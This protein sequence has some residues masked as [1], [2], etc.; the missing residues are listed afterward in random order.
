MLMVNIIIL[1]GGF[2]GIRA[3]LTL[4]NKINSGNLH[5]MII[6][7]N[8][9]HTFT[10]ALYE[11]A[12]AEELSKNAIIPYMSIFKNPLEFVRGNVE[13]IDAVGQKIF[14][15]E[16]REYAYNYLIFAPGSNSADF[17][18]PGIKEYAVPLITLEDAVRIKNALKNAKRVIVGGGGFTGTEFACELAT[19][20][21]H[22]NITLI[23]GLPVLLKELGDEVSHLAK[24]RLEK[25]NVHLI[26][27]KH[28]KK[29]TKD[30][31][32]IE[33][34]EVF[35]YDLFVWT[36]GVRPNNLLGKIEVET[37][38]AVKNLKNVFAAGDSVAPGVAP[39]AEEMGKLA[40]E[41]ILRSIN[42]EPL[43]PFKYHHKGYVVPLGSRF[44]TYVIGK[45]Q[46]FGIIAY[47][48]QQLI[49]LKY[50]LT[51][52][53]FF[54]AMKRFVKFEEDLKKA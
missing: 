32:E 41:N 39:K 35:P 14:L 22:L 54:E 26:L 50:L 18:I 24:K 45:Y 15:D 51:I 46:L 44:V 49:F 6:D 16:N 48:F 25:G 28:I 23:Q 33:G 42:S 10:P 1:G 21:S 13:K 29:V 9:F 40:A 19:K 53:P 17:G 34:G 43:L 27:G 31:V 8:N 2:A 30:Q 7:R 3:G 47:I 4:K 12:T 5:V 36:G 20:K 11:V 52:I 38:L 37:T